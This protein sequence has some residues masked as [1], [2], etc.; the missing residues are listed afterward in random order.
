MFLAIVVM[1]MVGTVI[2]W[3]LANA[4][5]DMFADRY[6]HSPEQRRFMKMMGGVLG[7][8]ALAP[9][10][11]ISVFVSA[12]LEHDLALPMSGV[13]WV[14]RA[15]GLTLVMVLT[16][17]IATGMGAVIGVIGARS[18]YSERRS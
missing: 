12:W 10:I 9:A 11:F 8:L 18:L 5:L 1:Y 15:L 3:R 6:T 16:V 17:L 2:A 7:T 14:V 4:L 13:F